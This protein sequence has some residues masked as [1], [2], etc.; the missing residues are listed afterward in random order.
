MRRLR[1]WCTEEEEEEDVEGKACLPPKVVMCRLRRATASGRSI[2]P[3][4]SRPAMMAI[5]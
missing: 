4:R 1:R 2:M 5:P 3:Q